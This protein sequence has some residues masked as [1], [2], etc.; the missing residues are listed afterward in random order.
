MRVKL[1]PG[2]DDSYYKE[3]YLVQTVTNNSNIIKLGL[4]FTVQVS[5]A[6]NTNTKCY[7]HYCKY[8]I[9]LT[10]V[11]VVSSSS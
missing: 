6:I 2:Y 8:M 4:M 9:C 7:Y 5:C 10:I 1:N 11:V 3:C